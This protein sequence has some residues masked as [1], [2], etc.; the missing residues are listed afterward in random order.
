MGLHLAEMRFFQPAEEAGFGE[1]GDLHAELG[2]VVKQIESRPALRAETEHVESESGLR[3]FNR[4]RLR[5]ARH[6]VV[7]GNE[8]PRGSPWERRTAGRTEPCNQS[9]GCYDY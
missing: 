8:F 1:M 3:G 7:Y 5:R 2:A 9:H 4:L 6:C